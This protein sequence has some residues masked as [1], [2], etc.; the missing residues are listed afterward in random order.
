MCEVMLLKV[1]LRIKLPPLTEHF[2]EL[3]VVQVGVL[4]CQSLALVFGPHHKCVHRPADAR[5]AFPA[6]VHAH[7]A[8]GF[9]VRSRAKRLRPRALRRAGHHG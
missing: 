9:G 4:L 7:V 8:L 5:F 3:G 6:R 2:A 1:M